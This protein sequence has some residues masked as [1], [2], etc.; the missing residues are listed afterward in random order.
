MPFTFCHP[1]IILPLTKISANRIS[2]TGL[3][4]GSMSPDFEYFLKMRME[5]IHGHTFEGLF[6]LDLPLTIV[7]AFI[8]HLFVRDALIMNL[9]ELLKKRLLP[10]VGIDWISWVKKR[11]YVLVYSALIGIISHI[12][13]DAFTHTNG[14]FVTRIPLLQGWVDVFG[15]LVRR[16][17]LLQMLSTIF[18]GMAILIVLISPK[19]DSMNRMALIRKAKYW[20]LILTIT[21]I[22]LFLRNIQTFGDFV[23]TFISGGLISL[24]IAPLL[25]KR[26]EMNLNEKSN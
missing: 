21:L 3:I 15:V 12:F 4:I 13:W 2:A 20:L 17:D 11:W 5:K 18:G 26:P 14:Y 24:I 7:L 9:P 8:F 6:Y 23:A 25:L 19:A 22:I 16:A 1:A 10:F